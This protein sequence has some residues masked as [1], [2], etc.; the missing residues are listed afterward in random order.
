[1]GRG[2][3]EDLGPQGHATFLGDTPAEDIGSLYIPKE[4]V[5]GMSLV[6]MVLSL[7]LPIPLHTDQQPGSN[8]L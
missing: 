3:S 2:I 8:M 7:H 1:M 5:K 6:C 4:P